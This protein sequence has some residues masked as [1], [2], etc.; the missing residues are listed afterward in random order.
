MK[1]ILILFLFPLLIRAEPGTLTLE[2]MNKPASLFDVA[3]LR[4]HRVLDYWED[5]IT[6]SYQRHSSSST[7]AGSI[8]ANY[9]WEDDKIYVSFSVTDHNGTGEEMQAGCQNVLGY[10]RVYVGKGVPGL[11]MHVGGGDVERQ[12]AA[13]A[14]I[15]WTEFAAKTS[16]MFEFRCY[17]S[18]GDSSNLRFRSSQTLAET[19]MKVGKS[20]LTH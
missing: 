18:G 9:S 10:L 14:N 20:S 17:V 1:K 19:E 12:S 2:L 16:E 7:H 4:L 11:F 3:M 8:N 13:I 15:Q 6:S 5:Q